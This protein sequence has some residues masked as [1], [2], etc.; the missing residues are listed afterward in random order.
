MFWSWLLKKCMAL[1][2]MEMSDRKHMVIKIHRLS[3]PWS[4]FLSWTEQINS[5]K[6]FFLLS[7][8]MHFFMLTLCIKDSKV[9]KNVLK[10]SKLNMSSCLLCFLLSMVHSL[11]TRHTREYWCTLEASGL[12]NHDGI[13][14]D[15]QTLCCLFM[16]TDYESVQLNLE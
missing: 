9:L 8:H 12:G 6:I 14:D 7:Y 4:P 5:L 2:C 13:G 3:F 15:D 16:E 11:D 1:L 10:S